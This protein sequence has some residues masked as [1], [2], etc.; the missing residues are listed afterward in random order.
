MRLIKLNTGVAHHAMAW[1]CCTLVLSG[2]GLVGR[3]GSI[4]AGLK[5]QASGEYRAAYIEA[6]KVLQH[7]SKNG[8][9]WLLLGQASLMLGNPTDAVSELDKARANGVPP[10]RWATPLGRALLVSHEY[11]KLLQTLPADKS[12]APEDAT[13]V[14]GLRGD[15]YLGLKQYVQAKQSYNAALALNPK[16]PRALIGLASLAA[17]DHDPDSSSKYVQQAIAASPD[18]PHA[19]VLKADLAFASA[20]FAGAEMDYQKVL[21]LKKP[22]WLPQERFYALTRLATAQTQQNELDKAL[23]SILALEKMSPR[24]PYPYYLHA[25]VLYKQGHLDDAVSKLQEVLKLSPDNAQAQLLMGAVN[26]AQGNYSQAEMYLSNTMGSDQKNIAA[27]KLLALTLYREGRSRQALDTLRP[28]APGTSSDIELL[29]LLQQAAAARNGLPGAE[30]SAISADNPADKQFASANRALAKGNDPEAIRLLQ[31]I[32]AGSP[33]IE[34]RRYALLV[35]AYARDK[36]PAE[37]VKAA[38]ANVAKN[39]QDS[40]AHLL[41][42]TALIAAGQRT[43]ARA[44]YSTAVKLD[45][46]N[47]AALLSLGSLDSLDGKYENAAEHYNAVLKTDPTNVMAITALGRLAM[48]QGD[49]AEAIKRYKQAISVAPKSVATYV[50]LVVLYSESGQF[51]EAVIVAKQLVQ[52]SPN[53]PEALNVL[54]AAELN[55]GHHGEALQPLQQAVKL[56]PQ[57]DLYR[58]NLA[59][60][61]LLGKDTKGAEGNLDAVIRANPAQ[62]TAVGLRASLK[63]QNHD[64]PGAIAL[65][66]TLQ[67]QTATKAAGF[68]LEGDLYMVNKSYS[69]AVQAY[70]RGLK[71]EYGRTL[72]VKSFHALSESGAKT[73]ESV[74]R[75]WLAKNPDDSA[76]R[77]LLADYY[78]NH[79]Q[80]ALAAG[81]YEQVLKK[82]PANIS[83]LNNLAWFYTEQ[84]NPKALP[85]AERAYKLAPQSPGVADTYAWALIAANQSKT[86]LPILLQ[87]TKAAPNVPAIQFHLAVAQARTG[88]AVSA[89]STLAALQKSATDFQGKPAAEKLYRELTGVANK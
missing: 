48:Q 58:I 70:Q 6:K 11:D 65:A 68:A 12:F 85:L 44:Q 31:A 50:G 52:A 49:E 30:A 18:D 66:Q 69:E 15:A 42:G 60:A 74:L 56:M 89:R 79:A 72:V 43:E 39:P 86:A 47:L 53:N 25:V 2:C 57:A 78:L 71:L 84:K 21:G 26:Y 4:D 83:A 73:P 24:H 10:E 28:A 61:Q 38:V 3:Q 1:L 17:I 19:W 29:A 51:E 9:A 55:A 77:L 75:D 76:T 13:E 33:A 16:D 67:K 23:A 20:D 35:M 46:K 40:A 8:A 22:D 45:P 80:S 5:Y 81:E 82:H 64:L 88:D 62:V 14:A 59:R 41:Y 34:A 32:P 63:L 54:G 27:R 36:R 7:D 87:A 37:A